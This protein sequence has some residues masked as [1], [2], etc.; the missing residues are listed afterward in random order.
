MGND[1]EKARKGYILAR[2]CFEKV[3]ELTRDEAL[4]K[5]RAHAEE[6]I[7]EID[8]I[9]KEKFEKLKPDAERPPAGERGGHD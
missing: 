9:L 8:N 5:G 2:R 3:K 4:G 6:R 1:P 7:E